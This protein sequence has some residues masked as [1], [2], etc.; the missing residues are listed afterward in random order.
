MSILGILKDYG[1]YMENNYKLNSFDIEEPKALWA[2]LKDESAQKKI[3]DN[4][5]NEADKIRKYIKRHKTEIS[6]TLEEYE[7][8][9]QAYIDGTL[10]D[11][12]NP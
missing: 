6:H 12:Y 4:K 11:V 2:Y 10:P 7:P 1:I 3:F 5:A 8:L 9:L